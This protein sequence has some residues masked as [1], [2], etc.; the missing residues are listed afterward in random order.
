VNVSPP[1]NQPFDGIRVD[2][3]N[4]KLIYAGSDTGVWRSTDAAAAWVY[5]GPQVGLPNTSG[6]DIKINAR[7]SQDSRTLIQF[8]LE[9]A[10]IPGVV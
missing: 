3:V 8:P 1:L 6:C 7:G 4:P 10:H 2:P 5:D 9:C